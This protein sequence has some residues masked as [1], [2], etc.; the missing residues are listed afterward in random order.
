M[1]GNDLVDPMWFAA[2]V[3]LWAIYLVAQPRD[4]L[5]VDIVRWRATDHL[6]AVISRVSD[7]NNLERHGNLIGRLD[8]EF[9]K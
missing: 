2:R 9:K 7:Y 3:A 1:G 6:A 8:C 4:R 5:A